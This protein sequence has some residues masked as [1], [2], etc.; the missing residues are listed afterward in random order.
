MTIYYLGKEKE[1][2]TNKSLIIVA[3]IAIAKF[4]VLILW[5]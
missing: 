4:A 1:F 2:I 5:N 3:I